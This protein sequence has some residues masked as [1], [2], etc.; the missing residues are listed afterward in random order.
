MKTNNS[1]NIVE[2]MVIPHTAFAEARQRIE[3]C[4]AFSAAKAE[5]RACLSSANL[6]RV[7]PAY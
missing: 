4:F 6:A 2:R 3:Q 1:A 5:A 7:R